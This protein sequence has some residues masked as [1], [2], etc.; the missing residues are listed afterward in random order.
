MGLDISTQSTG[1]AVLRPPTLALEAS[2]PQRVL[3]EAGKARLVEWGCILG[4]GNG[5]KK[6]DVL[7][8]G[9]LVEE[10]LVEVAERCR[11]KHAGVNSTSG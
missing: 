7:D 2:D 10:T 8:V 4:S 6:K 3:V 9:T 1:Y 5:S 11:S